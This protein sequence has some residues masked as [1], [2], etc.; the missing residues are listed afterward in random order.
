MEIVEAVRSHP[1]PIAIGGGRYSMGGQTATE[2]ALHIDMRGFNRIVQFS[3]ERKTITV[4][5]GTRWRQ[6]Q[7]RIDPA[8]LSVKIMQSYADFTVGGALSVNAHGRYVGLGP[9]IRSVRSLKV[10]LAD[11]AVTEASPTNNPDL[12][13]GAIGGYGGL[14]VI[15]EVTLDLTENVRVMRRSRI[16]P[17]TEY[18]AYFAD[19][20][21]PSRTAVFHNADIYPGRYATVNAIT[22]STTDAALTVAHRLVPADRSYRLNRLLLWVRS[23]ASR[24]WKKWN[25]PSGLS[26]TS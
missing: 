13:Y 8:D 24:P 3:P 17:I 20:V 18:G 1:G 25:S 23:A 2:G 9:L 4:Q 26:A 19:S 16:M 21:G 14:G 7:E 15:T 22:Y 12:F 11:G 5:A 10:V 6:I